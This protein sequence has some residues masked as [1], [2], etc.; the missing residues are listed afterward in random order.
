MALLM[1]GIFANYINAPE[2]A[3]DFAFFAHGF[4]ACSYLHRFE[5]FSQ[6]CALTHKR[7]INYLILRVILPLDKSYGVISRITLSPGN[8]LIIFTRILP[9]RCPKTTCPESSWTRKIALGK[10]S[11]TLP[12]ISMTSLFLPDFPKS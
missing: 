7:N 2:P 5:L 6:L 9:D 1:L 12:S 4:Y 3:D 8:T 10:F 11:I